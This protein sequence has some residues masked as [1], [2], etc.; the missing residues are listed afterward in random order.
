MLRIIA[1]LAALG[2]ALGAVAAHGGRLD[3]R[4]DI[5]S[6][7][8]PIWLAGGL[9]ALLLRMALKRKDKG[10]LVLALTAVVAAGA[11]MAPELIAPRPRAPAADAS[12]KVVQFNV[13]GRNETWPA[14]SRWLLREDADVIV[15]EE[16]KAG[17]DLPPGWNAR[18]P[19]VTTCGH[20]TA[21]D[22]VIF[23]KHRPL[24][25]QGLEDGSEP[26][27]SAAWATLS[28][29]GGPVTVVGVHYTRPN[30]PDLLRAQSAR[31]AGLLRGLPRDR[32]I[33]AG[34]FNLTPWSELLRR[35]DRAF[36]LQRVTRALPT[37]PG[38][39]VS[40]LR[41][42]TPFPVMPID[43][44]YVGPGWRVVRVERGPKMGSDHYPVVVVLTP[45]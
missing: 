33:V 43:H 24:V 44:V 40:G 19:Y 36:G 9:I 23:S 45:A 39:T 18:Y 34:D 15:L 20:P 5:L 11:L 4:L 17:R 1:F 38:G 12:I 2:S 25:Q 42:W 7:F 28:A 31:M 16:L 41:I 21:C 30:D 27:L 35:Q 14:A 32:L 6:H 3:A 22:T 29:P 37:W 26:F 10:I 13:W 8:A